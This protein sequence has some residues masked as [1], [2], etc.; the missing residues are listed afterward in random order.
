MAATAAQ[1]RRKRTGGKW[2]SIGA[3]EIVVGAESSETGLYN[4]SVGLPV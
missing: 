2:G 3:D 4:K 1:I